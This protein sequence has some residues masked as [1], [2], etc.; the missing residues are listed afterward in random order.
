MVKFCEFM[1]ASLEGRPDASEVLKKLRHFN[2]HFMQLG[3]DPIKAMEY[4]RQDCQ[5]VDIP[6]QI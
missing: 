3:S 1:E 2:N 4:F 6:L 5:I